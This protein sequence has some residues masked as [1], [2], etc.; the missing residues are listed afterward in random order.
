[1][2]INSHSLENIKNDVARAARLTADYVR[3]TREDIERLHGAAAMVEPHIHQISSNVLESLLGDPDARKIVE[4]TGLTVERA[5]A[6]FDAW[7][8]DVFRGGYDEKHALRV[9]K[10]GLAH[11][12]AGVDERLMIS[13][14]GAFARELAG[15]KLG[16]EISE[17]LTKA[18]FWN[19][20]VMVYSYE[21][22]KALVIERAIGTSRELYRRLV[23]I[24]SKTIYDRLISIS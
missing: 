18:L 14:M 22:V 12:M 21:Y 20:S 15:L 7:L 5:L 13:N 9:F 23:K 19:L 2:E 11:V 4:E 24:F 17:P 1:M 6:L 3:L 8:R 10:I 16:E